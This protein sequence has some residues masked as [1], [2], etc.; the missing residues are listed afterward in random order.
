MIT[1]NKRV[2]LSALLLGIVLCVGCETT[3][4]VAKGVA[5]GVPKDIKN[6]AS[7]ISKTDDWMKKNLW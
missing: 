4:N 2:L 5:E 7:A 6:T 1:D 3:K